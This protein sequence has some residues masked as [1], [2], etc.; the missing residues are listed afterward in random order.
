M[1]DKWERVG[2]L[3]NS[4]YAHRAIRNDDRIYVVG[5]QGTLYVIRTQKILVQ[6]NII[7]DLNLPSKLKTY[8]FSVKLKFGH[9]MRTT[10][11][12]T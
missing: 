6:I 10:I 11:Q 5:G 12:L 4:R 1:I 7:I 3:Q 2:N 9:A 8:P